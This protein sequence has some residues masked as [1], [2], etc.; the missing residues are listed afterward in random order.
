MSQSSVSSER[1]HGAGP[2]VL[3]TAL[4]L[5]THFFERSLLRF[6]RKLTADLPPGYEAFVML[7]VG[8]RTPR[9]ALLDR[10]PH[11]FATTSEI[12]NPAYTGKVKQG[13]GWHFWQGGHTDL[14]ALHFRACFPRFHRYWFVEYDMRFSGDWRSFFATLDNDH[15]D[16]LTTTL[17]RATD[18]P[19]WMHWRTLSV[20]PSQAWPADCDKIGAFMPIFRVSARALAAIDQAYRQGWGG[21]CEVT[22]PTIIHRSGLS[23]TDIGGDGPFVPAARRNLFY[24]NTPS[25]K[26]LQPGSLVFR[27]ARFR[28]GSGRGQLWHPVKPFRHKLREDLRKLWVAGKRKL[29]LIPSMTEAQPTV[30]RQAEATPPVTGQRQA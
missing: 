1:P 13:A 26:D 6:F 12:R 30:D 16:L 24:T 4:V 7:H 19:G 20:P 14:N 21:H 5:Q 15:G 11:M 25:D 10:V 18:D 22:W 17:R 3:R 23:I 2:Q 29:D 27:P 9:P 28:A 8:D